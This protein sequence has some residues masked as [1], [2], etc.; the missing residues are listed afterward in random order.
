MDIRQ[1][2]DST[3]LK[4]AQQAGLSEAE[5]AAVAESFVA[6]AIVNQFKLIMI[7]PEYV[8]RA[9]TMIS[10]A[11][12]NLV[13]GTVI[14]F[15]NGTSSVEQKLAEAQSAIAEGADELDFVC[16]YAAFINGDADLVRNEVLKCTT[17]G[18]ESHKIVKW[19]I[20]TAALDNGQIIRLCALIKNTILS[21]FKEAQYSQVFVKSSTGFFDAGDRPNGATIESVKL[22]LENASPLPVK[23][24]GGVRS[25]AE[26]VAMINLGAKRIGTSSAKAIVDGEIADS[27]Y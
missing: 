22:M 5:N 15:P 9:R 1:F 10:D 21:N 7:R 13:I 3:Y 8:S 27:N 23:A 20:E 6:E 4:T 19:I 25:Y 11:K 17:V 2:L 12:S 14:D 18:L 16:N 24:S 26:A